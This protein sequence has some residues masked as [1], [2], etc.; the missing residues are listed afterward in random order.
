[1][2]LQ[3]I[4]VA[5]IVPPPLSE[6]EY[7][8]RRRPVGRLP[9]QARGGLVALACMAMTVFAVAAWLDPYRDDRVWLEETHTQL[10]LPAC[11]FRQLT[12]LPCPSC[13]MTTSF[14]LFVRGDLWHAAQA[15]VAGLMLA[16]AALLFI[17]WALLSA[18]RGRLVLFRYWEPVL[19]RTVLAFL[20]VLFGRWGV[21]LLVRMWT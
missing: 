2:G 12:S 16:T 3:G 4:I 5:A 10:G 14:A 19:I 6:A 8:A 1:L 17:P 21:L 7:R 15:N 9:W 18:W 13:G 20:V 11:T